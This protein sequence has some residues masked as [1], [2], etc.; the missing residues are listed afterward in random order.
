LDA[1]KRAEET[2]AEE[3]RINAEHSQSGEYSDEDVD[4]FSAREDAK[5]AAARLEQSEPDQ[6][7][8]PEVGG[9]AEELAAD[10]EAEKAKVVADNLIEDMC[11]VSAEFA[12]D[13]EAVVVTGDVADEP[14]LC[15]AVCRDGHA[16]QFDITAK[17]CPVHVKTAL[18]PAVEP[19][20]CNEPRRNGQL[21]KWNVAV[22]P[23][24]LH[25]KADP[26]EEA[27]M[28]AARLALPECQMIK[29][30]GKLCGVRGCCYHAPPDQRCASMIDPNET[31]QCLRYKQSGEFCLSH[32]TFPN[33]SVNMV[34]ELHLIPGN[35]ITADDFIA[36]YYP[37][38]EDSFSFDFKAYVKEMRERV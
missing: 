29:R 31:L 36:K 21:C 1:K 38:S 35:R 2:E 7:A 30:N 33:L 19:K 18:V 9:D 17:A 27:A 28:E 4:A 15:G 16:C 23:C 26:T 6:N 13:A 10:A 3:A 37:G 25:A 20:F 11:A 12:A 24:G 5:I 8:G 34:N 22:R 32:V 14:L